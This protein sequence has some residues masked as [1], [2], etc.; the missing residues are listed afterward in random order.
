LIVVADTSPLNYLIEID[1][2][3]LLH[4]LYGSIVIPQAVAFELSHSD[5]PL[6]VREWV[7][8]LPDWANT[9]RSSSQPDPGLAFLDLGEREA[10]QIALEMD[11]DLLLIDERQGS[12]E[13][14]RRGLTVTGTLGV[15][16]EAGLPG[17]ID[18][19]AAYRRLIGET[20][21]RKSAELENAF[22]ARVRSMKES[23]ER[24][25]SDS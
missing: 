15:L 18:P 6:K 23:L 1:C 25:Q 12:R 2:I 13:A 9:R 20:N 5:A 22:L 16:L 8:K 11:A 19:E 7:E 4:R 10:I 14:E 3:D 17:L 21:F 24:M